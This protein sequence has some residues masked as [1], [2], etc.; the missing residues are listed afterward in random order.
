MRRWGLV[1]LSV[2]ILSTGLT[3]LLAGAAF[4][5][6]KLGLL[7]LALL[8]L[9]AV[10][11]IE[12]RAPFL[13]RRAVI[14][15][16]AILIS[17]AVIAPPQGSNDVWSYAI[18]GR[19]L[20]HYHESP[21]THL[22]TE[23]RADPAFGRVSPYWQKAGSVYG[24]AFTAVSAAGMA[25]AG[26]SPFAQRLFFQLLA[27]LA[28]AAALFLIDRRGRDPAALA[29]VGLN[30]AVLAIVNG[31]HNDLLLGLAVLGGALLAMRGRPIAAGFVLA[32][33]AM[34]KIAGLLPL[35]ALV[36]W[37]LFK[38]SRR[39]GWMA[40]ISGATTFMAGYA[41]AGGPAALAPVE[42]ADR[43]RSA[44]SI[45]MKAGGWL[46]SQ[47]YGRRLGMSSFRHPMNSTV[48]AFAAA[49]VVV[50]V[51]IV[52]T[53]RLN[54]NE[55]FLVAGSAMIPYF[56]AAAL[57]QPWYVGWALPV[58]ALAWR[59]RLSGLAFAHS[60]LLVIAAA[61]RP[62]LDPESIHRAL[63]SMTS[64]FIPAF[65]AL[66]IAALLTV[67]AWRARLAFRLR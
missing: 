19:I 7:I 10:L 16:A 63:R 38:R 42:A 4:E 5:A 37:I 39:E 48:A 13:S 50:V 67:S 18:Y 21:Y 32:L 58:L 17:V 9:A 35:G 45:W 65:E 11:L 51:I 41:L 62:D 46:T 8:G 59:S 15:G 27:A 25:V 20:S 14:F 6:T 23:Y 26:D 56:L 49:S 44:T 33:G 52:V 22:P 30:P 53:S 47:L 28:L 54:Y 12:R 55:P 57:I 66:A 3:F 40:G 60:S 2:S 31:G 34:V 64:G 29:F 1:A 43:Y 36:L 61:N 24:P